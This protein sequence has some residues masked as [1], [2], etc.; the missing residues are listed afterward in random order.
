VR[1]ER[2]IGYSMEFVRGATL[3]SLIEVGPRF[4][5]AEAAFLLTQ[6]CRGVQ[7]IHD[8]G[9]VHRDIKPSNILVTE[10]GVAKIVDLGL[11]FTLGLRPLVFSGDELRSNCYETEAAG[12]PDY[13]APETFHGEMPGTGTD[14]YALGVVGYLLVTGKLPF[15]ADDLAGL[16]LQK[17]RLDPPSPKS[18]RTDCPADLSAVLFRAITRIPS[19]RYSTAAELMNEIQRCSWLRESFVEESDLPGLTV[20][21]RVRRKQF[22]LTSQPGH[23]RFLN[24]Q[25]VAIAVIVAMLCSLI[26]LLV[27]VLV[28]RP[29]EVLM[30]VMSLCSWLRR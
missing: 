19:K 1:T 14:V 5:P 30:Q 13:M 6:L 3:A 7:A 21:A 9:M 15:A 25:A 20:G 11:A 22:L 28:L 2:H 26:I 16:T 17:T 10:N 4:A 23:A 18:V 27:L 12:S 8:C 29:R 24:A